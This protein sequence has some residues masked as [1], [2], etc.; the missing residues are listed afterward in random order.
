MR[1]PSGRVLALL[2]AL[3][4]AGQLPV[5]A[6]SAQ[7]LAADC[8]TAGGD[9][10]LCALSAAAG[11]DLM[12]DIGVLAGLGSDVPGQSSILGSRLGGTPRFAVSMRVSGYSVVVP[13]LAD[14]TGRAERS[15]WVP[16]VHAGLALGLFDGFMLLPTVGGLFSLD[17]F[18][19][20]SFLFF[21]EED[22]FDG[23]VDGVSVGARVGLIRESFTL[24]GV[25]L[26]VSRRL[27]GT[28]RLGDVG[29]GDPAQ[30]VVDP[31]VTS[32]RVTVGK[33]LFAFG[34]HG[35]AGWDDYSS[36][37][38]VQAT[39]GAGGYSSASA[40]L[41]ETRSLYFVGLSRQLG[42]LTWISAEVGWQKGFDPVVLGAT[43][44]SERGWTAVGSLA[45]LVKL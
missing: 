38:T 14:A 15:P 23:R 34:V 5:G 1:G 32:V 7:R 2:A 19:Q 30:V 41:G 29:G 31:S 36:R 27:L 12:G 37:T 39:D 22:G 20:G 26:A 17:L 18:S 33:D 8:A 13:D 21:S 10:T 11:R 6:Q 44:S 25:T 24:P 4:S 16:G 42:I 28:L 45:L 40:S 43:T 3:A 35:G 9:G